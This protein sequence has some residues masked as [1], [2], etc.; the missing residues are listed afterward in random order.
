MRRWCILAVWVLLLPIVATRRVE[1]QEAKGW[2]ERV[3]YFR[4][5][6]HAKPFACH[7]KEVAPLMERV[8]RRIYGEVEIVRGYEG[9]LEAPPTLKGRARAALAREINDIARRMGE[10][11]RS[12]MRGRISY[13]RYVREYRSLWDLYWRKVLRLWAVN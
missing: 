12:Y 2:R 9:P 4:V 13:D 10:L 6:G 11:G 1:C 7:L 5:K 3:V 8:Y